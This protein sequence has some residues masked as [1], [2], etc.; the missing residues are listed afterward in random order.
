[1]F[2]VLPVGIVLGLKFANVYQVLVF[3][4][5]SGVIDPLVIP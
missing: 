4:V 2:P 3:V 5:Q 1:L